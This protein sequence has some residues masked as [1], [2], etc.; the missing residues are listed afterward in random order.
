MDIQFRRDAQQLLDR[1]QD[2]RKRAVEQHNEAARSRNAED[3]AAIRDARNF[4]L[5]LADQD[6]ALARA[7]LD[8][9]RADA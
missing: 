6:I 9:G 2:S 8:L 5:Q 1:A 7:V 3:A 4:T